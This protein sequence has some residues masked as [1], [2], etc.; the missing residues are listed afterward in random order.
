MLRNTQ[1]RRSF[2]IQ[3][4]IFHHSLLFSLRSALV[5]DDY[6]GNEI[7]NIKVARRIV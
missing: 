6:D 7:G 3:E 5:D 1:R 2:R 4:N